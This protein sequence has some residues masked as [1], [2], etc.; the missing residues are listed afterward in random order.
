MPKTHGDTGRILQRTFSGVNEVLSLVL[1]S[2]VTRMVREQ[3]SVTRQDSVTSQS[4]S[5]SD[6]GV[7]TTVVSKKVKVKRSKK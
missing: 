7:W 6:A 4:G 3:V 5:D 1:L 2:L